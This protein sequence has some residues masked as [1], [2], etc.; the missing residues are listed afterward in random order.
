MALLAKLYLSLTDDQV[1]AIERISAQEVSRLDEGR[2]RAGALRRQID[3][4]TRLPRPSV[5]VLGAYHYEYRT[6]TSE[7]NEISPGSATSGDPCSRL[8]GKRG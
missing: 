2:R 6:I 3:F 5:A 8:P 7:V 4:E 1:L